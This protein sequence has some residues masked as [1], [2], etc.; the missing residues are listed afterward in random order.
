MADSDDAAAGATAPGA[1]REPGAARGTGSDGGADP[2]VRDFYGRWARLYDLL[3]RRTPLVGS[4]RA[5]TADALA[6]TP[7][8]TVVDVGCGTGATLPYL[9]ERV[10][11][12]GTVVGV[13]V[14]PEMLAQ[15]RNLVER[16]GWSNVHLALG[17]GGELPVAPGTVDAVVATFVVGMFEAPDDVVERWC[18]LLAPGGRIA[19]LNAARSDRRAGAPVNLLL[20]A[21]TVLSTPPTGRLR[22]DRDLTGR[23]TARVEAA[24]DAVDRRAAVVDHERHLLGLVRLTHGRLPA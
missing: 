20:D 1:G 22:Y 12:D 18:D 11:P 19:L 21:V 17:D 10:G 2:A 15:A 14:T 3:A 7:G 23:L 24:A 16:R 9:R 4:L 13:D 8:D 6:L 5:R